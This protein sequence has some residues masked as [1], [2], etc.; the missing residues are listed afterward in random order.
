MATTIYT[1]LHNDDL[2]GSRIVSMDDCMCMLYNIKRDDSSF[3]KDFN[4][5]LQ[6]PA[7]YILLNKESRKAY[8]G[9]TDD[10]VKR[11]AQHLARKDFWDE[12]LVFLGSNEDTI[13]KTEVQY[14]EYL[15]YH[16]A[17]DVK[18]YDLS[19]N[20]QSPKQPHMN[21]MQKGKTDKFFQY[22]QFLAQFIGCDIF[23][24]R[25]NVLY[26]APSDD[27]L[28]KVLPVSIHLT[29]EDLKGNTKLSFN[30]E[31][32]YSKRDMVLRI[33][34]E[35]VRQYPETTYTE[36]RATFKRDYLGRFAQYEFLQDDLE[37]ARKWK[38]LGEDHIHYFLDDKDILIS[39]DGVQFAVCVEWDKNNI[40]NVLGIAKALGWTFDIAK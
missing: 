15:A 6:K 9:E 13:S 20:T 5:N 17:L 40:I 31:G 3:M 36:L 34:K 4:E 11:I 14:L 29:S 38:E 27:I 28:P 19:E 18:T 32:K 2:K 25:Q 21:V 35:F 1:Y 8:I 22:V 39:S 24:K 37:T 26:K 7:L 10:F 30:G 23:E 12:V 16:K 33:V